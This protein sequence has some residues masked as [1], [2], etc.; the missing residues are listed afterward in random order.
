MLTNPSPNPSPKR[1]RVWLRRVLALLLLSLAAT[2]LVAWL[3]VRGEADIDASGNT[4]ATYSATPQQITQG[5]YIARAGNCAACHTARGGADYAGGMGIATPFGTVY[6]SNLTPDMQTGLGRWT[7]ATFWRAMHHGRSADGRLLYPVF[8]YTSYTQISRSDSDA[9]FAYLHS[10]APV[11]QAKRPNELAFP[12]STQAALAVWRAMFFRATEFTPEPAHSAEWNRGAYL[13]RGLGHCAACHAGRNVLGASR[14]ALALQGGAI[15]MQNW[16]APSLAS[17]REAGVADWDTQ[18]VV[19]LLKT[20]TSQHSS[21]MGPMADVV[22]GSTQYLNDTDLQAMAV[23]L[24]ELPQ[25]ALDPLTAQAPPPTQFSAGQKLYEQH[26][27]ECHGKQGEGARGAYPALAGNRVVTMDTPANLVQ[28]VLNGGY[29]P[30]TA[31]NPR[32]YGMPPFHQTLDESQI[33]AVLTYI[34][35]AWGH[36]ASPVSSLEV[37]QYQ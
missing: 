31:G 17:S 32:P 28:I 29:P 19:A 11:A 12:Y 34:R 22:F 14:S 8:P 23:F 35:H 3:N 1:S 27:S 30:A 13:V 10:L 24:K 2:A 5:A 18:E 9:L 25:Q 33:A 4:S 21:V 15:P 37:M 36:A 16:Y 7:P 20:G 6:T 26:C